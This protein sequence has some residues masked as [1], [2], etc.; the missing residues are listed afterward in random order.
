MLCSHRRSSHAV[1][2]NLSAQ[3]QKDKMAN[4]IKDSLGAQAAT[5]AAELGMKCPRVNTLKELF[6]GLSWKFRLA[7]CLPKVQND[8]WY[9]ML[10][11]C[12]MCRA[13][14]SPT[15]QDVSMKK[16][17]ISRVV[18]RHVVDIGPLVNWGVLSHMEFKRRHIFPTVVTWLKY[19]LYL[20]RQLSTVT[21]RCVTK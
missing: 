18:T 13:T 8:R 2:Y 3:R 9:D 21:L 15:L 4:M 5:L 1:S 17:V 10:T 20:V 11:T 12:L 14:I 7:K 16:V 6:N 19:M